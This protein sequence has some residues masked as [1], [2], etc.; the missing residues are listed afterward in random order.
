MPSSIRRSIQRWL[1]ILTTPALIGIAIFTY[2]LEHSVSKQQEEHNYRQ[3]QHNKVS[4][5]ITLY[6]EIMSSG[7]WQELENLAFKIDYEYKPGMGLVKLVESHVKQD[8]FQSRRLMHTFLMDLR[9]IHACR[10]GDLCDHNSI[11]LLVAPSALEIFYFLRPLIYC[12]KYMWDRFSSI[13]PGA[14]YTYLDL[15]KALI[16]DFQ[17]YDRKT[18][19]YEIEFPIEMDHNGE[20]CAA[21]DSSLP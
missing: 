10:N 4:R 1:N 6:Q 17:K 3:E 9:S 15:T 20:E 19:G 12:D 8:W 18:F 21:F 14:K 16:A 7:T 11:D 13:L 5:S 2:Q